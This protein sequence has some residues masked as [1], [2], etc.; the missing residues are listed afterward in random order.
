MNASI[1]GSGFSAAMHA[2]A[3]KE[4]GV[5]I[6]IVVGKDVKKAA[7]FAR[8]WNIPKY[9]T[10]ISRAFDRVDCVHIC[11]PPSTHFN[12]ARSAILKK[13][14]IICEKPL[15]LSPSEAK[16]I[17]QLASR[18]KIIHAVNFNVRYHQ[19]CSIARSMIQSKKIGKPILI[20]GSYQQEF[21]IPPHAYDWRY[22]EKNATPIRTV[23]EIGSHWFDL[24]RFWTG[25]EAEAVSSHFSHF[26]PLRYLD[27]DGLIYT[28]Y[29]KNR[30][31][32][33]IP[34]EDA[35]A[36]TLQFSNGALGNVL[37]SEV[38][39][40]RKNLLKLEVTGS[41]KSVWWNNEDPYK[42]YTAKKGKGTQLDHYSFSGGFRETT[43]LLFKEVYHHIAMGTTKKTPPYPT[44]LDGWK[45]TMICQAAYK[46]SLKKGKWIKIR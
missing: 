34:S 35:A 9:S 11:T 39:H 40:G 24:A 28:K 22:Q 26:Q 6:K 30:W 21:H 42:L 1:I 8:E 46:S 2:A 5:T 31:P 15:C 13:K 23:S 27:E 41:K 19:A 3:L 33:H 36:I 25:L 12:I 16:K 18:Q 37:L 44:F 45:N 14:H 29:K 10:E 32:I 17:F 7:A 38:S 43:S 20:H 4:I